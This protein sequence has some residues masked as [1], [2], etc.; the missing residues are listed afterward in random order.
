VTQHPSIGDGEADAANESQLRLQLAQVMIATCPVAWRLDIALTGSTCRGW[1]DAYSDIE[2]NAWGERLPETDERAIW[3]RT[4]GATEIALEVEVTD[5]GAV[6]DRW[7]YQDIWVE[8]GWQ[9]S[10]TLDER[11][12]ATLSGDLLD[13]AHLMLTEAVAHALPLRAATGDGGS[14]LLDAWQRRL[15]RYP[16]IVRQRLIDSTLAQWDTPFIAVTRWSSVR[17]GQSLTTTEELLR[18]MHAVLRL[19]FALNNEWEPDWKWIAQLSGRLRRKPERLVERIADCFGAAP[20]QA[21]MCTA[22]RLI[23][24]TLALLPSSEVTE[25][26]RAYLQ[27]GMPDELSS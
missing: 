5:D 23:L 1:A 7:R 26:I 6:W 22:T 18:D 17:R 27:A 12:R 24:D 16:D 11:L 19:L 4:L 14:G 9:S 20:A 13:H 10:H 8:A 25:R 2:L 15:A 3:L 21:R